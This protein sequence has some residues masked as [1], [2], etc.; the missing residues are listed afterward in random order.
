[1]NNVLKFLFIS[2]FFFL[3][4][5]LLK[6]GDFDKKKNNKKKQDIYMIFWERYKDKIVDISDSNR[7]YASIKFSI[8]ETNYNELNDFILSLGFVKVS[9]GDYCKGEQYMGVN[10]YDGLYYL[11]Y[12]YPDLD[13]CHLK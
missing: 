4:L 8:K 5:S 11:N 1:M 9:D 3:L 13:I 6:E 2:C 12:F 10:F 7:I